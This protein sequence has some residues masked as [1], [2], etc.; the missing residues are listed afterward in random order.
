MRSSQALAGR[1]NS[2][3]V[4]RLLGSW[5]VGPDLFPQRLGHSKHPGRAVWFAKCREAAGQV[6]Q[7]LG[8]RAP[9][10][11][12]EEQ[13]QARGEPRHRRLVFAASL[14]HPAQRVQ[15]QPGTPGVTNLLVQ[16]QAFFGLGAGHGHIALT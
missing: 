13:V 15:R 8:D 16:R 6:F 4:C 1:G 12:L 9:G 10:T 7:T 14:G 2:S 3:P 11:V 5:P